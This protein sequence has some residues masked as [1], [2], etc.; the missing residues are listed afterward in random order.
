M[1][2][3]TIAIAGRTTLFNAVVMGLSTTARDH[4]DNATDRRRARPG[5]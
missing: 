2:G 1:A 4:R 3:D 5:A